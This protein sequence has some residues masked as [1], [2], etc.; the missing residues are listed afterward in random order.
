MSQIPVIERFLG[1]YQAADG[2]F[3]LLALTPDDCAEPRIAAALERQ[4]A[5]VS[6]HPQGTTPEADEVRLA[7]HVAAAQLRDP[8]VKSEL[9]ARW[10]SRRGQTPVV[11]P[12]PPMPRVAPPVVAAPRPSQPVMV[13][14][15]SPPLRASGSARSFEDMAR[16]LVG[17]AGGWNKDAK[18]RLEKLASALAVDP[19]EYQRVISEVT[20]APAGVS[21]MTS[22]SPTERPASPRRRRVLAGATLGLLLGSVLVAV[23]LFGRF[24]IITAP[25]RKEE[26]RAIPKGWNTPQSQANSNNAPPPTSSEGEESSAAS[27]APMSGESSPQPQVPTLAEAPPMPKELLARIR[28]AKAKLTNDPRTSLLEFESTIAEL[29]QQWGTQASEVLAGLHNEIVDYVF[30]ASRRDRGTGRAALESILGRVEPLTTGQRLTDANQI[31]ASVWATGMLNRL[32]RDRDL[33]DMLSEAIEASLRRV[34]SN[35]R[36]PAEMSNA[37]GAAYALSALAERLTPREADETSAAVLLDA[38]KGWTAALKALG[39]REN[40]LMARDVLMTALDHVLAQGLDP[41]S[42]RATNDAVRLLLATADWSDGAGVGARAVNWFD[43]VGQVTSSDLSVVTNWLVGSSNLPGVSAEMLL[44]P[45]ASN[46]ERM[47]LRDSYAS[48]FGLPVSRETRMLAQR[49]TTQAREMIVVPSQPLEMDN[50]LIRAAA[51]A[52]MNEAAA[53]RWRQ[54]E[55]ASEAVRESA[56]VELIASQIRPASGSSSAAVNAAVLTAPGDERDGLWA[57]RYLAS[58]NAVDT[59]IELLNELRN[60]GGPVGP[61]DA[62]VL[63]E[64]ACFGSPMQI[65]RLAQTI[66]RELSDNMLVINAMLESIPRAARQQSVSDTVES[67]TGTP[68]PRVED[69]GW[70][71]ESR[72]AL[73]DRM[74]ALIASGKDARFDAL[75]DMLA[76]SYRA[77]V[78]AFGAPT[79]G[80]RGAVDE[81][82]APS[83]RDIPDPDA[84]TESGPGADQPASELW[85]LWAAQGRRYA[86]G[87]WTFV[88]LDVLQRRRAGRASLA[89]DPL[90]L[91]AAEQASGAEVMGY[92]VAAERPAKFSQ[93]KNILDEMAADRRGAT[94]LFSQMEAAERAMLRLWLVRFG[95][96]ERP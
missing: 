89:D 50:S 4:L 54:Q 75:G 3:A 84:S 74:L 56:R 27:S 83:T 30:H 22:S 52:R 37:Q 70:R 46:A 41:T 6:R 1:A 66:V 8:E 67:I 60:S 34:S 9:T 23:L 13:P 48:L 2:P 53:L 69:A 39:S 49:W 72:R 5:R 19:A 76:A 14:P 65:R 86:E 11:V 38:W 87:G 73:V 79:P 42:S 81:R 51:L 95:E 88:G 58:M 61:A 94:H 91:F 35:G 10:F 12:T 40:A 26:I 93:V 77:R 43:D 64:A 29:S 16:G 47:E 28:S 62:D 96:E 92:V 33:P 21:A 90:Q 20:S 85:E 80:T 44:A 71:I 57:R 15:A 45:D 25:D 78:N 31:M 18:R 17:Q 68:L 24:D 32:R 82:A 63:G 36:L 7:L 59:R 55:S